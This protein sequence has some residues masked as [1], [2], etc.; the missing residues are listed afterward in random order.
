M[1]SCN[2]TFQLPEVYN[3][4]RTLTFHKV[5][6]QHIRGEVGSLL[7]NLLQISNWSTSVKELWKAVKDMD[8]SLVHTRVC[9]SL[10]WRTVYRVG[11]RKPS[12]ILFCL[13][14]YCICL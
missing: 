5:V 4:L 1:N 3:D 6:Y 13:K 14:C 12:P 10:F 9:V 8:K 2:C 11:H 7:T